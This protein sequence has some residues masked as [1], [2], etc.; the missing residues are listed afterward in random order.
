MSKWEKQRLASLVSE[1]RSVAS[2][3]KALGLNVSGGNYRT[4]Y[5]K[6]EKYGI[7]ITHFTGQAHL[8]GGTHDWNDK[9][10]IDEILVEGSTYA[11]NLK[12]RVLDAGLLAYECV[13][14]GISSWNGKEITLQLDHINGMND[15]HRLEN[16]QLLC[17]NCH[18]QTNTFA[19]RNKG[20]YTKIPSS[21]NH[22]IDCNASIYKTSTRCNSCA[23][24]ARSTSSTTRSKCVDCKA[25]ISR[26]ATRCKSCAASHTQDTKINWPSCEK[27]VR[28][29]KNSN[30]SAVSRKLG[31]SDNAIRKRL[32]NHYDG[33]LP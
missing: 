22:C 9:I 5:R 18:S 27:L 24:N 1:S 29:V 12:K 33:E 30:Y 26:K 32:R 15:D 10:P 19:G 31:V 7:D 8:K 4:F 16:L 6:V 13:E 25:H 21:E 23:G 3:I 17:P 20:A 11:G 2:V 28:M 14:C